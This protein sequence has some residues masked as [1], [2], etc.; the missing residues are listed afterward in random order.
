[1]AGVTPTVGYL[2]FGP[3]ADA[4]AP[5]DPV[6]LLDALGTHSPTIEPD[7]PDGCWLDVR[8]G[9][10][11][12]PVTVTAAAI[13]ATA[14]EW[15]YTSARLGLAPTPGVA[16]LGAGHSAET[17]AI[18]A[19]DEVAAF[20]GPLSLLCLGL[21][22]DTLDRL[23]LVGL[24][25]LGDVAALPRGALGDY[26]LAEAPAIEALARG[27]DDRPLVPGRSPLILTM[28]RDLDWTLNDRGQLARLVGHLLD[29]MLAHLRR[30]GLG[31][32]RATLTLHRERGRPLEVT[33]ALSAATTEGQAILDRLLDA[34]P[35]HKAVEHEAAGITTVAVALSA[36][37]PVLGRQSSFFD[38][39]QG[40]AGA[41]HR[42]MVEA[43]QRS[44]AT[45]GYL[46]LVDYAHP[47]PEGRY[48]LVP[49]VLPGEEAA[50]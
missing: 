47:L 31:A 27:E 23:A 19:P 24:R 46:R 4:T 11:A 3:T 39:P 16:R 36:P 29:P 42:G 38:V 44:D 49:A 50:P 8:G 20:L 48:A 41:L 7:P 9:K 37:R 2:L 30:Q 40:R 33:L 34:L 1:M 21:D 10:R 45:M 22:A 13:L 18:L 14:S 25:T 32:T 43:R 26:L 12:P 15:G 6:A 5:P 35:A 28:R 17:P